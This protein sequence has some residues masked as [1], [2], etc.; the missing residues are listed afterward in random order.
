MSEFYTNIA[1]RG[2][3]ILYRGIDENGNPTKSR[4]DF[5]PT[6]YVNARQKTDYRLQA[7]DY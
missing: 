2:N 4:V 5:R 6:M 7:T 1:M 3:S